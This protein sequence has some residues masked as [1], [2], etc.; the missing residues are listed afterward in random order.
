MGRQRQP[1]G[2][3]NIPPELRLQR[4][5]EAE[6]DGEEV[7]DGVVGSAIPLGLP[8]DLPGI[9]SPAAETN[10]ERSE[11][12]LAGG[13]GHA[14]GVAGAPDCCCCRRGLARDPQAEAPQPGDLG[15]EVMRGEGAPGFIGAGGGGL[16]PHRLAQIE[17]AG[18]PGADPV[19]DEAGP[20]GAGGLSAEGRHAR[21]GSD[22]GRVERQGGLDLGHAQPIRLVGDGGSEVSR[23][24]LS[25]LP[26]LSVEAARHRHRDAAGPCQPSARLWQRL[27]RQPEEGV[28]RDAKPKA[29][30]AAGWSGLRDRPAP[31]QRSAG[32]RVRARRS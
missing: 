32:C 22:G 19:G 9:L 29:A 24:D 30:R 27:M 12:A 25:G 3:G 4:R 23:R 18:G 21:Q 7:G 20:V 28:D 13:L 1:P 10:E 15:R 16:W 31:S 5:L 14:K 2:L 8:L 6:R 26:T 17:M 11:V